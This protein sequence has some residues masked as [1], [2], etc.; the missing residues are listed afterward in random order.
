LPAR[1]SIEAKSGAKLAHLAAIRLQHP[2][3]HF[4]CNVM[5]A[6]SKLSGF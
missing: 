4:F 5:K 3:G 6:L 1:A 2:E